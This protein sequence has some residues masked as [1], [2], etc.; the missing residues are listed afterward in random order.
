MTCRGARPSLRAGPARHDRRDRVQ[1]RD[2]APAGRP[3]AK[4][5]DMPRRPARPGE[6][7]V[8]QALPLTRAPVRHAQPQQHEGPPLQQARW[9]ARSQGRTSRATRDLPRRPAASLG[10]VRKPRWRINRR[11]PPARL[12]PRR[13]WS[14]TR[15]KNPTGLGSA[16]EPTTVSRRAPRQPRGATAPHARWELRPNPPRR[17]RGQRRPGLPRQHR[18][19]HRRTTPP[20][21]PPQNHPRRQPPARRQ[22]RLGARRHEDR[23]AGLPRGH[24][25][26]PDRGVPCPNNGVARRLLRAL[27]LLLRQRY[28]E[29][30]PVRACPAPRLLSTRRIAT[31][32]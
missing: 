29:P 11:E 9:E 13:R 10:E 21:L 12:T 16:V 19:E 1:S 23:Q 15:P 2:A 4:S 8:R 31:T 24:E 30:T 28:T 25:G 22:E 26:A 17:P 14:R 6:C 27:T 7:D 32:S 18:R 3:E 5:P 20:R